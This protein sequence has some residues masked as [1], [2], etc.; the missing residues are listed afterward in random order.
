MVALYIC[1]WTTE[2]KAYLDNIYPSLPVKPWSLLFITSW[3]ETLVFFGLD[4]I[5]PS[6]CVRVT[7]GDDGFWNWSSVQRGRSGW[8]PQGRL[9][10]GPLGQ[11]RPVNECPLRVFVF[12]PDRLTLL[13][14]VSDNIVEMTLQRNYTFFFAF[15]FIR[16]VC[17]CVKQSLAQ[18]EVSLSKSAKY[19]AM[20]L[21]IF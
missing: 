11:W 12:A 20:T 13:L 17:Y 8:R 2:N 3:G 4:L 5:F 21:K 6:F 16:S 18:G 14:W 7:G 10:C 19:S 15:R 1:K 9:Q